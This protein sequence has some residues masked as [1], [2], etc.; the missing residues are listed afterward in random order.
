MKHWISCLLRWGVVLALALGPSWVEAQVEIARL[1]P[2][3]GAAGDRFGFSVAVSGGT[4]VVGARDDDDFDGSTYVFVE[5]TGGW[6]STTETARVTAADGEEF[7]ALGQSIAVAGT[8]IFAGAPVA[9]L[10][11]ATSAAR[12]PGA[13]GSVYVFEPLR[14]TVEIPT[15]APVGLSALALLL[16]VTAFRAL[17]GRPR[18]GTRHGP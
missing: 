10:P 15:L 8:S 6:I 17:K 7:D 9:K 14:A 2:S 18:D 4:L 12:G 5:P 11:A 16:L 1:D 13:G 3:D